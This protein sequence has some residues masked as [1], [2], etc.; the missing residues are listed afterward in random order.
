MKIQI[1]FESFLSFS[2]HPPRCFLLRSFWT[3]HFRIKLFLP[4][5]TKGRSWETFGTK[6]RQSFR[7]VPYSFPVVLH[8]LFSVCFPHRKWC[9]LYT[10]LPL[11]RMGWAWTLHSSFRGRCPTLDLR[12]EMATSKWW[13][14]SWSTAWTKTCYP[15][16][17]GH[18]WTWHVQR[19]SVDPDF[20]AS[21]FRFVSLISTF[22][23]S[24]NN[25]F[26]KTKDVSIFQSLCWY[27]IFGR[28]ALI[29][30]CPVEVS[31]DNEVES[32]WIRFVS[33]VRTFNNLQRRCCSQQFARIDVD[34]VYSL[35]DTLQNRKPVSIQNK[36]NGGNIL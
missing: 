9:T 15:P 22:G 18:L 8:R 19:T 16:K 34:S 35:L 24:W 1:L 33:G 4:K 17:G 31:C 12:Q 11:G 29:P 30:F 28:C 21:L 23:H 3:G 10:L 2:I 26:W 6:R 5:D 7:C 32:E 13:R 25:I 36:Q 20:S 14:C 27:M